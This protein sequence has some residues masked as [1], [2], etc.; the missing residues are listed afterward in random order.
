MSKLPL[1]LNSIRHQ[2][3][4]FLFPHVP[5]LDPTAVLRNAKTSTHSAY[6]LSEVTFE[7]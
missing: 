3:L 6:Y 7:P 2:S 4:F 1:K 5:T